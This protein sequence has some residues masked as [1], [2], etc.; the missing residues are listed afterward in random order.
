[1]CAKH[2]D[3]SALPAAAEVP[4]DDR[5]LDGFGPSTARRYEFELD[6]STTDYL[7][8]LRTYSNHRALTPAALDNLLQCIGELLEARYAG[9]IRKRSLIE[10][11]VASRRED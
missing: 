5:E 9:R 11:R 2:W 1:V 10:L 3:A 7:D 8:I 4:F 6:Y